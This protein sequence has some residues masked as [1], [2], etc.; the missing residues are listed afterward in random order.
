MKRIILF[1]GLL[2]ATNLSYAAT[3]GNLNV[4][5]TSA[6]VGNVTVTGDVAV[7]GGDITATG[8]LT[9]DPAGNDVILD[10]ANLTIPTTYDLI[11]GGAGTITHQATT[12]DH[13]SETFNNDADTGWLWTNSD[14]SRRLAYHVDGVELLRLWGGAGAVIVYGSFKSTA[15]DNGTAMT[16]LINVAQ[17]S[18]TASDTFINFTSTTGS[19]G[20]IA[21]TATLG[22][23][24]Y[25]TFTGSHYTQ[26]IDKTGLEPNMLLEIVEG[27]PEFIPQTRIEKEDYTE[28]VK[29]LEGKL[30]LDDKGS[31]TRITKQRDV[32]KTYTASSKE[33]L[34]KTRICATKKSKAAVGVYGG[35]DKEGRDMCLSLGTG[36]M[37]VANKGV[38][39]E[40]G[41]YLISSDVKGCA[42]KQDDDIYHNYTIGKITQS[43]KWGA[44]EQK[45]LVKVIYEGG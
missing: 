12:T 22:L 10:N 9:L 30:V 13:Y 14:T 45:R 7:N 44:L 17:A 20:S 38:D 27:K 41:D 16:A 15:A 11:F 31:P 36:F 33:Q 35:T 42:E 3:M 29:D 32:E 8:D 43:V 1:M 28:E 5:Q 23:I 2:L 26:V 18:I 37:W 21:G 39:L 24:A 6:L 25:N 34:F 19:E 4:E 40:I